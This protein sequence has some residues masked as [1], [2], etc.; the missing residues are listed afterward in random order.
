MDGQVDG[1]MDGWMDG[2]TDCLVGWLAGRLAG[3]LARWLAR[4]MTGWVDRC[5]AEWMDGVDGQRVFRSEQPP[6]A[7]YKFRGSFEVSSLR[8]LPCKLI[9]QQ[10]IN[11]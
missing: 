1:W 3:S 8:L 2:W 9:A 5:M 7:A 6:A 11:I 10:L 4:W